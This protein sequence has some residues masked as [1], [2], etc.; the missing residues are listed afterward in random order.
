MKVEENFCLVTGVDLYSIL[1]NAHLSAVTQPLARSLLS[2]RV[3]RSYAQWKDSLETLLS[4]WGPH[5]WVE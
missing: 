1:W 4:V 2:T 5:Q 3:I